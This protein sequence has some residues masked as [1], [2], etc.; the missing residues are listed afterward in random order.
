MSRWMATCR[1]GV[2]GLA[3]LWGCGEPGPD[4]SNGLAPLPDMPG[5]AVLLTD[6]TSTAVAMLDADGEVLDGRWVHSGTA[7]PGLVT[8]LSGDVAFPTR[9]ADLHSLTLL[10]RMNTDVITR[11]EVPGGALIGQVRTHGPL[12]AS[13]FSSNPQDVVFLSPD[14]AWVSRMGINLDPA[15]SPENQGNDLLEIDPSAMERTGARIDLSG[16]NVEAEPANGGDP[17]PTYARPASTVRI[18]DLVVVGLSRLSP[19]FQAAGPGMIAVVRVSDEEV[20]GFSLEGLRNCGGIRPV[21]GDP[22]RA[23][24]SCT[25]F[26]QPFA[27][28]DMR[29]ANSGIVLVEVEGDHLAEVARWTPAAHPGAALSVFTVAPIGGTEVLAVANGN[30]TAGTPDRL[31]RIDLMTGQQVE[32]HASTEAFTIGRAALDPDTGLLLVPDAATGLH[33][34]HLDS[35]TLTHLDAR[36]LEPSLGLPARSARWLADTDL[37]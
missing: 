3:L 12:E 29:R 35:D 28:E 1:R 8:A 30:L 14:R 4:G 18:G 17:I 9:Q 19:D 25:G 20:T 23:I 34:Y 36:T 32:V 5:F 7:A 24:V 37:P 26:A 15:A 33:R 31:Y 22:H 6:Y 10:D 13:G 27:D 16:F 2:L 11:F 21:V